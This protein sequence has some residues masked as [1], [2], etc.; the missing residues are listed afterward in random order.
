[1]PERGH[2]VDLL[3]PQQNIRAL[4]VVSQVVRFY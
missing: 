3:A 4:L 1:M 2:G